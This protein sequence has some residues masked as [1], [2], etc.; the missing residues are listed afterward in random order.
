M[1]KLLNKIYSNITN[2]QGK[3]SHFRKIVVPK[4]IGFFTEEDRQKIER[5]LKIKINNIAY[6]EEAFTHRSYMHVLRQKKIKVYSNERLEFFGDAILE[7]VITEYIFDLL[8]NEFEGQL[9]KLRASIVSRESMA[10]CGKELA[11]ANFLKASFS[12]QKYIDNQISDSMISD[13]LEAIIGA[14]YLDSGMEAAKNFILQVLLPIVIKKDLLLDT[15]YKSQLM[16][17]VQTDGIYA[18]TYQVLSTI[19]AAH[20]KTYTVGVYLNN[21]LYAQGDGPTKKE[22]ERIAAK[23]ALGIYIKRANNKK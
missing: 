19:G 10:I 15:N 17:T 22:A 20:M 1:N 14:V 8:T 18:P 6:F 21:R 11:I 2:F 7:F 9:T 13:L 16:E 23:K 12:A 5:T 4:E 3:T